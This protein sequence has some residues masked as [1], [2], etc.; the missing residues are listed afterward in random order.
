[1]VPGLTSVWPIE[2]MGDATRMMV[3]V[4]APAVGSTFI[5]DVAVTTALCWFGN[6][7]G[8]ISFKFLFGL[9]MDATLLD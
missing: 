7:N 5:G 4:A 2:V 8:E 1:L 3:G 9:M 6:Y